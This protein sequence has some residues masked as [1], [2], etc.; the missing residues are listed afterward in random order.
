MCPP[1][2]VKDLVIC[3][4]VVLEQNSQMATIATTI[5]FFQTPQELVYGVGDR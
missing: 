1:K 3:Q 2:E 5:E 4:P